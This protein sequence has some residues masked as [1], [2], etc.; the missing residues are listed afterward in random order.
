MTMSIPYGQ[1]LQFE[2]LEFREM[3]VTTSF[4]AISNT[5]GPTANLA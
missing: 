3:P 5:R 4:V 2:E 1:C